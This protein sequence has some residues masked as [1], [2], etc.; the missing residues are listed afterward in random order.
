M[1]W[2]KSLCG[3]KREQELKEQVRLLEEKLKERQEAINRTNAYWK[4][5][6]YELQGKMSRTKRL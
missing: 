3:S 1:N 5:K 4:R 2:L 6:M